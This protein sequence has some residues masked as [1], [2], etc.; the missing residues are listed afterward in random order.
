[1]TLQRATFSFE[2]VF[3]KAH[4]AEFWLHPGTSET[5]ESLL[6]DDERHDEFA[7][8][9]RR[10][11]YNNNARLNKNGSNDYWESGTVNIHI[12]LKDLVKIFH[13]EV[14]PNHELYYYSRV[15]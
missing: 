11:V 5:I 2:A 12:V 7:A 1:M 15:R 6:A 13:P 3:A 14:I 8:C 4:R 10:M 9:K